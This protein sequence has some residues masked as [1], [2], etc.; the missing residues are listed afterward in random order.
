MSRPSWT[1]ID[2]DINFLKYK[3]N[4][5]YANDYEANIINDIQKPIYNI[6]RPNWIFNDLVINYPIHSLKFL[7]ASGHWGYIIYKTK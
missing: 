7:F 5:Q 2:H 4:F 1:F 6:P 3:L